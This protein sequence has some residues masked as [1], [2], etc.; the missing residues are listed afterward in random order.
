[1]SEE[2]E[3]LEAA[4]AAETASRDF[5]ARVTGLGGG[6]GDGD[7][8]RAAFAPPL[9]GVIGQHPADALAHGVESF[10]ATT[11]EDDEELIVGPAADEVGFPESAFEGVGDDT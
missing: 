1:L 2:D 8:E 6:L 11:V 4:R 3:L 7:G 5:W 9:D 10:L